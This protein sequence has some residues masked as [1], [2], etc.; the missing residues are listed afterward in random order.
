MTISNK[1]RAIELNNGYKLVEH[2]KNQPFNG[3]VSIVSLIESGTSKSPCITD[4]NIKNNSNFIVDLFD[5]NI[6]SNNSKKYVKKYSNK[7]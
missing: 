4:E 1:D 3:K 2:L 6:S 5:S 7:N